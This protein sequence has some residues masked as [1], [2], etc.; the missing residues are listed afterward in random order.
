MQCPRSVL[1]SLSHDEVLQISEEI[2]Q[3][4][5]YNTGTLNKHKCYTQECWY[6]A[7][8]TTTTDCPGGIPQRQQKRGLLPNTPWGQS[9]KEDLD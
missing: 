9:K 3:C 8:I 7:K 4:Y 2:Q 6:R 5:L 1:S